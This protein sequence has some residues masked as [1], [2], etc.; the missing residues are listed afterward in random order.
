MFLAIMPGIID[1]IG[2][3]PNAALRQ[4]RGLEKISGTRLIRITCPG[5]GYRLRGTQRWLR[6]AVPKCPNPRCVIFGDVMEIG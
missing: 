4:I 5:C 3:Y 1:R 2:P 6:V